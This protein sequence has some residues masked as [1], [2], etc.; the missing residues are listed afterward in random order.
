LGE[1]SS[2]AAK[3]RRQQLGSILIRPPLFV[4]ERVHKKERERD[5]E[6][7]IG[8]ESIPWR[9]RRCRRAHPGRVPGPELRLYRREEDAAV[10]RVGRTAPGGWERREAWPNAVARR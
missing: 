4:R 2:M 10:G 3:K 7:R 6:E 9:R 8:E 1:G 5:L